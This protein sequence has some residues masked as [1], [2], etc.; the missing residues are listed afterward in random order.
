MSQNI[1]KQPSLSKM[2]KLHRFFLKSVE[3]NNKSYRSDGLR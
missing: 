3:S 1:N 2:Q